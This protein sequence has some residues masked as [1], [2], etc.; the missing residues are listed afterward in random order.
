MSL[1][2]YLNPVCPKCGHHI[3]NATP[4]FSANITHN[5]CKMADEAGIYECVWRP[6]EIEIKNAAQLI[7]MLERG[8]KSLTSMPNHFGMFEPENGWGTY[9]GFVSF[10]E[11]Y[12]NAC[13]ESPEAWI[14]VSR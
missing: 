4:L 1:N 3:E 9:E 11:S 12:L 8:L 7:P 2:V 10:L 14:E 6:D 13:R 5:L